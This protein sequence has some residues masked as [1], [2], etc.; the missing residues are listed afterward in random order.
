MKNQDLDRLKALDKE[1]CWGTLQSILLSKDLEKL[2][3]SET[4]F[5]LLTQAL[6]EK[7]QYAE[8]NKKMCKILK[9]K[10]LYT[11]DILMEYGIL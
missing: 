10:G 6:S 8:E 11:S 2:Q 7:S 1:N 3:F 9:D 4:C 5:Y